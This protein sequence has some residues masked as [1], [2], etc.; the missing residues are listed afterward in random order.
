[1]NKTRTPEKLP[2]TLTQY[3][4]SKAI[5]RR[6][7]TWLTD[8]PEDDTACGLTEERRIELRFGVTLSLAFTAYCSP[9]DSETGKWMKQHNPPIPARERAELARLFFA[10]MRRTLRDEES[11]RLSYLPLNDNENGYWRDLQSSAK[12]AIERAR[13][14]KAER[15]AVELRPHAARG[16]TILKAASNGGKQRAAENAIRVVEAL[17][18]VEA[19]RLQNP[20]VSITAARDRIAAKHKLSRKTLERHAAKPTA[21]K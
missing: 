19:Y 2:A 6:F 21:R 18:E 11:I 3:K 17:A 12:A 5:V 1:M 15:E 7:R 8:F 16:A 4:P 10:I 9:S 13:A 20:D 14:Q